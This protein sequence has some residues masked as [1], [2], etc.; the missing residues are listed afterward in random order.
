MSQPTVPS[1]KVLVVDLSNNYGGSSSRVLSLM[2]R[3]RHGTI[4]LAGLKS[5][6]ITKQALQLGLPVHIV[7]AHKADP[8]LLFRLIRVIRHEEYNLLD[9]Q[10]IQ[11]KF[12]ASLAASMTKAAF[13]STLNS[14]YANEHGKAS[15]KGKIYTALE[16]STNRNLDLYITVSEKDRQS[17]LKSGLPEDA[18]EL[19]YNAVDVN[20]SAI[21]GDGTWLRQKFSLPP[22]SIICTAVGRLVP[23]KG[24]DILIAAMQK[25]AAQVP[26]LVCLIVG[27]GQAKEELSAQIRAAGLEA[28]VRLMGYY[29]RPDAMS[30]LKSSDIFVMPSRYEGTPIALLEAAALAR[31]ILASCTGGI[32]ELVTHEEHALLVPTGDPD[33]LAQGLARLA[34]DRDYAQ[35]LGQ[36]AQQRVRQSFSLEAQVNATWNAY[37]KAI[38]RHRRREK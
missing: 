35:T 7:A 38:E 29:A 36:K 5:G 15:L 26:Q 10:N 19:I 13:V 25:I 6:A 28:R 4:A 9:S 11:S 37:Q 12:W 17:L 8:R 20:T 31:P 32:P 18:V 14:W 16:L 22:D 21:P 23:V 27:E 3:A 24:Y 33:S 2:E 1:P 30:I 34:Q